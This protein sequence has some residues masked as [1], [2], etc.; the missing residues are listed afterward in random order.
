MIARPKVKGVTNLSQIAEA[1]SLFRA[2]F[3][4][5]KNRQGNP[6]QQSQ[7]DEHYNE[8]EAR[9]GLFGV[10]KFQS[11]FHRL[12]FVRVNTGSGRDRL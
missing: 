9:E 7:R 5:A 10:R 6:R 2:R 3:V 8:F 12:Y 1:E 11:S 4:A